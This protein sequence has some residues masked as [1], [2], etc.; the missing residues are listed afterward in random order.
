MRFQIGDRVRLVEEPNSMFGKVLGVKEQTVKVK[1][2]LDN[3]I[4]EHYDNDL[5]FYHNLRVGETASIEGNSSSTGTVV[6]FNRDDVVVNVNGVNINQHIR[7]VSRIK[8]KDFMF[9]YKHSI[10]YLP[11]V[12]SFGWSRDWKTKSPWYRL[13]GKLA[14]YFD[15]ELAPRDDILLLTI[16]VGP[17]IIL[18]GYNK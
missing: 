18:Y 16:Y 12:L 3:S 8:D 17:M 6:S 7:N 14:K 1:W 15:Y 10:P 5:I 2:F 4:S 13:D 9:S 11:T